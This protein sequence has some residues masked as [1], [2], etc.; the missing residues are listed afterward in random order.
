MF[1]QMIMA[2]CTKRTAGNTL[3]KLLARKQSDGPTQIFMPRSISPR[4]I[5]PSRLKESNT[6]RNATSKKE[7]IYRVRH[8]IAKR[9]KSSINP[10]I[11][12]KERLGRK[13]T[14]G[15]EP[16]VKLVSRQD[17]IVLDERGPIDMCLLPP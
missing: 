4:K 3:I 12:H 8:I 14:L 10:T 17:S 6:S 1:F 9:G 13:P 2:N 5:T 7:M 15:D 11:R 16:N